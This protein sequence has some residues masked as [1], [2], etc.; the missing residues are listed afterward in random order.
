MQARDL[1]AN[2]SERQSGA[3]DKN[4]GAG[5]RVPVSRSPVPIS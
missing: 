3:V 4:M 2:H 5:V 1:E